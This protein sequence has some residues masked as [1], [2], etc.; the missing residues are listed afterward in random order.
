MKHKE[1]ETERD[2]YEFRK[3][4]LPCIKR[5]KLDRAA[6]YCTGSE[7]GERVFCIVTTY[8]CL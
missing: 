8:Y 4:S 3:V 1:S 5:E 6:L 7:I 2:V